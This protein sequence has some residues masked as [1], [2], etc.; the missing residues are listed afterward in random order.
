MFAIRIT[1]ENE[2]KI[3]EVTLT[4]FDREAL[5]IYLQTEGRWCWIRGYV[6]KRGVVYQNTALPFRLIVRDFEYDPVRIETD[7]DQIV[8]KEA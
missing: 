4:D 7:W 2:S 8:R 6:N 3:R 5:D 1:E